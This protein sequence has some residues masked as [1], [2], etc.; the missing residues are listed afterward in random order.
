MKRW[1]AVA[2]APALLFAGAAALA[3]GPDAH[4]AQTGGLSISPALIERAAQ[5]GPV[6]TVTVTNRSAAA[7]ALTVAARPWTQDAS[8]KVVANRRGTLAGVRVSQSSF[9]L[10]PGAEQK[11][12]V[13]LSGAPSG[14]SL[15]GALEVIGIPADAAKRTGVIVGYRMIGTLRLLPAKKKFSLAAGEI[16]R[17]GREVVLPVTNAGNTLDPVSG[18]VQIKGARGTL[19]DNVGNVSILPG[20][21]VNIVVGTGLRSGSYSATV[22]L[23]QG[24]AKLL[25]AKRKFSV[26]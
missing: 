15:Y 20:K 22:S 18:Q 6:G 13:T 23:K 1:I 11:I 16:K 26:R 24:G 25:S 5:P 10:V 21:K 8:G 12:D 7:L 19:N 14:G 2:A 9:T 3:A 4:T 17:V